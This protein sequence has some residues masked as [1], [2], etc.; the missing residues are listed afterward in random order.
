LSI[1]SVKTV[2]NS[3]LSSL[4]L[5]LPPLSLPRFPSPLQE[6]PETF[7]SHFPLSISHPSFHHFTLHLPPLS[8][9]SS[10]VSLTSVRTA[11]FP[12]IVTHKS[13][14]GRLYVNKAQY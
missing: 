11:C 5:P 3:L 9:F 6:L 13:R 2:F 1:T 7:F 12:I 10:L 8:S 14:K 4:F